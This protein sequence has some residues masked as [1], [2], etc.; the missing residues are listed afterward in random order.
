MNGLTCCAAGAVPLQ[1]E[2]R[3]I[4]LKR[5]RQLWADGV[6]SRVLLD[7]RRAVN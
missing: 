2:W 4:T 6:P 5:A 1:L 3:I 7:G